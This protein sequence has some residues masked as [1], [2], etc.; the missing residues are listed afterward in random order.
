MSRNAKYNSVPVTNEY[1]CTRL[2]Q[3]TRGVPNSTLPFDAR[4]CKRY[5]YATSEQ[6]ARRNM[7]EYL[8]IDESVIEVRISAERVPVLTFPGAI[9]Y[10]D[11]KATRTARKTAPIEAAPIEV[12]APETDTA[13]VFRQVSARVSDLLRA[14]E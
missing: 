14:R 5:C 6:E 7:A 9:G 3:W 4:N 1:A 10:D 12:S 2:D 13:E 11:V 8:L